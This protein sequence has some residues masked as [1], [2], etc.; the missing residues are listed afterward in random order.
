MLNHINTKN[1]D[2]VIQILQKHGIKV[3][4][5]PVALMPDNTSIEKLGGVS[6]ATEEM[7]I[8]DALRRLESGANI[9]KDTF[10]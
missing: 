10:L 6:T 8:Y 1:Q 4:M 7:D 9:V 3:I 2:E 5:K